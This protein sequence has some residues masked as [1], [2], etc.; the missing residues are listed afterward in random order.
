MRQTRSSRSASGRGAKKQLVVQR[1]YSSERRSDISHNWPHVLGQQLTPIPGSD[2]SGSPS[3]SIREYVTPT[4]V[5]ANGVPRSSLKGKN[6]PNGAPKGD[7]SHT[8]DSVSRPQTKSSPYVAHRPRPP[9]SLTAALEMLATSNSDI[10]H[11]SIQRS[12]TSPTSDLSAAS[13]SS[14]THAGLTVITQPTALTN[15]KGKGNAPTSPQRR[16]PAVPDGRNPGVGR[17]T[18]GPMVCR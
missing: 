1:S 14:S 17:G 10:G 11:D 13:G 7:F 4:P 8:V 15:G 16:I 9:Q 5:F 2:V 12:P 6:M 3:P 18:P